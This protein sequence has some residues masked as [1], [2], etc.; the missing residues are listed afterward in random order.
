V[1]NSGNPGGHLGQIEQG[2]DYRVADVEYPSSYS[3][4]ECVSVQQRNWSRVGIGHLAASPENTHQ[5][6]FLKQNIDRG[7]GWQ[8]SHWQYEQK[9]ATIARE[10]L[11][12]IVEVPALRYQNEQLLLN[13]FD[14]IDVV[15]VD[16]LLRSDAARFDRCIVPVTERLVRVLEAMKAPRIASLREGLST[17]KRSY[18]GPG[19]TIN[20][21]GF[22]I[23]N[24]GLVR[25]E[26]GRID[27]DN[28][29]AF[30]FVR[31]YLAPVEEA[32]AKLFISVGLLNWGKPLS[33]FALGPDLL[34][35]ERVLPALYPYL[36]G[37]AI[38]S[39]LKLQT[40]FRT[41]EFQGS[42][43]L[44]RLFKRLGTDTLGKRYL[45]KLTGWCEQHIK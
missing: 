19:T 37:Q 32:A 40:D 20:F 31:P 10:L 7:G 9:G 2:H 13:V 43:H 16:E 17:K 4:L 15:T 41:Q 38:R 35:L 33:R 45:R 42:G 29:V 25:A 24:T 11:R 44:E 6:V 39:E 8:P 1:H 22:E 21:K 5:R 12:D 18:G 30:D 14:Y 3:R 27:P 23:R 34:L 36:E 28:L 26:D